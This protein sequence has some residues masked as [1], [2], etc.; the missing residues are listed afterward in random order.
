M[1]QNH[2]NQDVIVTGMCHVMIWQHLKRPCEAGQVLLYS[3]SRSA[4]RT[5]TGGEGCV[6]D[7]QIFLPPSPSQASLTSQSP[8][9]YL[10]QNN[11]CL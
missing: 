6:T 1:S 3:L 10:R 5:S 2:G 11:H 7:R 9:N 4:P 8:T